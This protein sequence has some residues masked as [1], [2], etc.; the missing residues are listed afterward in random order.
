MGM[1]LLALADLLEKF[2]KFKK[3]PIVAPDITNF[4][5]EERLKF[6]SLINRAGSKINA[7]TWHTS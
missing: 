7:I 4:E 1:D 3:V 6:E 2:P 5:S